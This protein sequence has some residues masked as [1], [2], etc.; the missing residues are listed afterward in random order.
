MTFVNKECN[1]N[2][3]NIAMDLSKSISLSPCPICWGSG[4]A[5]QFVAFAQV[6]GGSISKTQKVKCTKCRGTGFLN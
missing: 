2:Y 4:K 1:N 3:L 5:K 6:G